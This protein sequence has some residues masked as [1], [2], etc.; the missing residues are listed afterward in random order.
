[1]NRGTPE[2]W[3]VARFSLEACL[4]NDESPFRW[5]SS[6]SLGFRRRQPGADK[7]KLELQQGFMRRKPA[8]VR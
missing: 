3:L 1:M 2:A 7:L 5:S 6:F 4:E 8:V